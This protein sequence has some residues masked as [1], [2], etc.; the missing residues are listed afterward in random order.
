MNVLVINAGSSTLK[1][2]LINMRD[3][4]V[5]ARGICD[6][7]GKDSSISHK[8]GD[9]VIAYQKRFPSH[10][11]ALQEVTH[12]LVYGEIA[13][14]SDLGEIAAV[15]HRVVHGGSYFRDSVLIDD[16]V[17]AKILDSSDLAPLHNPPMVN[18]VRSC[19]QVLPANVPH[20]AVFDTAFHHSLPEKAY[21]YPIPASYRRE[22]K[23]R[24]YG[25]HGTSHRFVSMQLAEAMGQPIGE[26]KIVTC[27][28]GNGSTVTAVKH[29]Q[30]IDTSAGFST[31]DGLLMG[32]RCG[33][34]DP[35]IPT[36]LATKGKL[37]TSEIEDILMKQS[38]L[39]GISELS[40]DY[41]E[42]E[43]AAGGGNTLAQL[44]LDMYA[45]QIK[46]YIGSYAVAMGGLDGIVFTGGIGENSSITR[47]D[48]CKDMEFLGVHINQ[49]VNHS[50]KSQL[51]EISATNSKVAIYV[52]PTNEELLIARDTCAIV[53][54]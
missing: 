21:T 44:A 4:Q 36:Y 41:R 30:S 33:G 17:L 47:A 5:I 52:I 2:Q 16:D 25:F 14:L 26:L 46:K 7:I 49:E 48:V 32:T 3:E 6:K 18:A 10:T 8:V 23:I 20:V 42:L 11:E 19:Q 22:L 51:V 34:I 31:L 35:S 13:V 50:T 54:A 9:Q 24:R 12:Q 39:L 37:C 1:Y 38:G 15:G 53:G 27:H 29:G 40:S 43:Q 28:L 45:Y